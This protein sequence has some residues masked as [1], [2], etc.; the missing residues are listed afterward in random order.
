MVSKRMAAA[1]FVV[2]TSDR[3]EEKPRDP[4]V[5]A[6]NATRRVVLARDDRE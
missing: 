6:P 1:R 4:G 5:Y 3:P 2:R